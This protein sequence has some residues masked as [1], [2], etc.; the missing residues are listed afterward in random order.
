[1]QDNPFSKFI[2]I[3]REEGAKNNPIPY[4]RG[5]VIEPMP[6]LL[7]KVEE[8]QIDKNDILI[9]E[10]LIAEGYLSKGDRVLIIP[11][12]DAQRFMIVCKLVSLA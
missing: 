9:N 5:I 6:N 7:I 10:N 11:T 1:M 4:V 8:M 12:L 3:I 2:R